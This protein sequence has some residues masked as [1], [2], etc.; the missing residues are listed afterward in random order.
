LLSA[1][2]AADTLVWLATAAEPGTSTGG[3]FHQRKRIP[4]S[5]AANDAATAQRLW[6]ESEK[7]AAR[8]LG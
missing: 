6:V 7:L 8:V 4:T 1:E 5:A 3:Y 2:D